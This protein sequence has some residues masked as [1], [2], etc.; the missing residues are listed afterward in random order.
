MASLR[1]TEVGGITVEQAISLS[2]LE[3]MI[4]EQREG[5]LLPTEEAFSDLEI[6]R[7][8]DFYARL[9]NSGCEIYQKKIGTSMP[10]GQRVRLY[11]KDG[12]FSIGEVK[13]F[14]NGTAIKPIK[15]FRLD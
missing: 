15:K 2:A 14:E 11:D 5:V 9:C 1:R 4:E 6:V 7:L 8:P 12:F 13:D 10:V 3:N